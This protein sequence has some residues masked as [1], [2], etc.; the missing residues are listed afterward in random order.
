ME[1]SVE[2][3]SKLFIPFLPE[4]SQVN[5]GVYGAELAFW[6]A[7]QLAEI[8][9]VTSYPNFEDWGWFIEYITIERDEFW[10]CCGNREGE[11]DKWLCYLTP[12]AKSLFGRNKAN[13][14]YALPLLNGL[15]AVLDKAEG[16]T[17][18]VWSDEVYGA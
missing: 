6:L 11:K 9:V 5:Q 12:K 8:G 16:I 14:D 7:Q 13:V 4:D 15:K 1:T 17:N 3:D 10:L 2:F 18:V